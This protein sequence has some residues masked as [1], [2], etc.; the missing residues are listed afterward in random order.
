MILTREKTERLLAIM[1]IIV[2]WSLEV[3]EI[4]EVIIGEKIFSYIW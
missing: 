3:F 2:A 1:S 4:L